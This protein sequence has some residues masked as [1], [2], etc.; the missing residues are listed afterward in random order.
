M[1]ATKRFDFGENW[2]LFLST[3]SDDDVNAAKSSL[4]S[5]IN[6][7]D[8]TDKTFLDIGSGSGLFSLSAHLLGA[9]VVSF[10]YDVT[11]VNCTNQLKNKHSKSALSWRIEQG[12]ILDDDTTVRLTY[13]TNSTGYS[14]CNPFLCNHFP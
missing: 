13:Q 3:L 1:N 2:K 8:L 10:D 5:L 12:D 6:A 7:E 14:F 4:V 9:N 11:S